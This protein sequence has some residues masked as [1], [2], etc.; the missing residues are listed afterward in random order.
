[1]DTTRKKKYQCKILNDNIE[2]VTKDG[3][4]LKK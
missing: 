1:M 2:I 4:V 3:Y